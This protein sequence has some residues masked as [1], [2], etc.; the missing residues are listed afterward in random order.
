VFGRLAPDASREQAQAQLTG[1]MT[2]LSQRFPS[3]NAGLGVNV[4]PLHE[5]IAGDVRPLVILLQIAVA[6][7][8]QI[9]C[10]NVA[11]L[12]LRA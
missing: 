2:E 9:A 5:E 7:L 4:I 8:M 6:V 12:L 1:I 10:A 11:H 3:T